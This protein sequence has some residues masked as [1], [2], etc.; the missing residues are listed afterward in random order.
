VWFVVLTVLLL[1]GAV[2]F[3]NYAAETDTEAAIEELKRRV[4]VLESRQD[5]GFTAVLD[6]T[7]DRITVHWGGST[8][9]RLL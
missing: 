2:P 7:K 8:R 3:I 5:R 6:L 4:D 9:N 1:I